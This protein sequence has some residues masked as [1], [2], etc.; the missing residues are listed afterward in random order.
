M[1]ALPC[2]LDAHLIASDHHILAGE[3]IPLLECLVLQRT[4][5]KW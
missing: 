1:V 3:T 5:M 2:V 4:V